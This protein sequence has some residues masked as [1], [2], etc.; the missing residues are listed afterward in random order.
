MLRK[1]L[2]GLRRY[3]GGTLIRKEALADATGA[4]V[5]DPGTAM[6]GSGRGVAITVRR[7]VS[8][9]AREDEVHGVL[10]GLAHPGNEGPEHEE[11]ETA[12]CE[13]VHFLKSR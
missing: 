4:G 8:R 2:P 5:H 3:L 11:Q 12:R 9:M 6:L 1:A 7:G 10:Y 13:A